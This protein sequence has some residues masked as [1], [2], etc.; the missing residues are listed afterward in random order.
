MTLA[1]LKCII[2]F[3]CMFCRCFAALGDMAKARYLEETN[4]IAE[5]ASEQM[6]GDTCVLFSPTISALSV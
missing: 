1:F 5:E 3:D 2:W 6:V 4:R